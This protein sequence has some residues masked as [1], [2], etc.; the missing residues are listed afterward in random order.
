MNIVKWQAIIAFNG[1]KLCAQKKWRHQILHQLNVFVSN[2]VCL[3]KIYIFSADIDSS[4]NPKLQIASFLY[5]S[6]LTVTKIRT[7]FASG[8]LI[9]F[10]FNCSCRKCWLYSGYSLKMGFEDMPKMTI[11]CKYTGLESNFDVIILPFRTRSSIVSITKKKLVLL[12]YISYVQLTGQRR[13]TGH[14]LY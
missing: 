1:K 11:Y 5:L 10:F 3:V 13:A 6:P 2:C 8:E 9:G 4:R 12:K 14:F 7:F